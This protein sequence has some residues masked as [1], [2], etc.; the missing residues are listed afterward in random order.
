MRGMGKIVLEYG[1]KR[2]AVHRSYLL[3]TECLLAVTLLVCAGCRSHENQAPTAN[4]TVMS[5]QGK[6][7]EWSTTDL[8]AKLIPEMSATPA[9]LSTNAGLTNVHNRNDISEILKLVGRFPGIGHKVQSITFLMFP[10]EAK[11][12]NAI[13]GFRKT[14]F[15]S[16]KIAYV[17]RTDMKPN[18]VYVDSKRADDKSVAAINKRL[19][20]ESGSEPSIFFGAPHITGPHSANDIHQI[21]SLVGRYPGVDHKVARIDFLHLMAEVTMGNANDI[22]G[23]R[24]EAPGHWKLVYVLHCDI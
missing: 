18:H 23:F 12:N 15:D 1:F 7:A 10:A 21:L 5:H 14:G 22:L 9:I 11:V 17:I 19:A 6:S 2:R 3:L 20:S 16:W 8:N 4:S 24:K 13:L